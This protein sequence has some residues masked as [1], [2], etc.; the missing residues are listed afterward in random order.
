MTY[1]AVY[2]PGALKVIKYADQKMRKRLII[3]TDEICENPHLGSKLVGGNDYRDKV[4]P[5]RIVYE[6]NRKEHK[7]TFRQV[8]RRDKVYKHRDARL[9]RG[10][11]GR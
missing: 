2:A 8:E 7:V 10:G 4:G 11:D 3:R 6:I 9:R 1:R 5:Y